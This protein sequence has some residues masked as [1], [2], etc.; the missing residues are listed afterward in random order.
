LALKFIGTV[1]K[2]DEVKAFQTA[3]FERSFITS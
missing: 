2:E 3:Q 1:S